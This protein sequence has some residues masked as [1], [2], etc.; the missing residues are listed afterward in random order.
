M[1]KAR[2]KEHKHTQASRLNATSSTSP[3]VG[4]VFARGFPSLGGLPV[5]DL[6]WWAPARMGVDGFSCWM[7]W[8]RNVRCGHLSARLVSP[9]LLSPLHPSPF[10]PPPLRPRR[11]FYPWELFLALYPFALSIRWRA[12]ISDGAFRLV[13]QSFCG[14]GKLF[15]NNQRQELTDKRGTDRLMG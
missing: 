14:L 15:Q 11:A 3:K 8:V 6:E 9:P 1:R 7:D 4:I 13:C 12:R 2:V 5:G 10:T